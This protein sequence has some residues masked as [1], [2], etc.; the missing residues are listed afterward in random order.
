[1]VREELPPP[2]HGS[3]AELVGLDMRDSV[4]TQVA[5]QTMDPMALDHMS[6]AA[7]RVVTQAIELADKSNI[8]VK[9]EHV[10]VALLAADHEATAALETMGVDMR[11]L[12]SAANEL[13]HYQSD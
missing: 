8:G 1:M 9:A 6:E 11:A 2:E 5:S 10:L 3:I 7:R 13:V 12:R 4:L